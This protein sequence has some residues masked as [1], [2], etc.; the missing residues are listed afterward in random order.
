MRRTRDCVILRP[1]EHFGVFHH[2]SDAHTP[3]SDVWR[4]RR[5][6]AFS[7]CATCARMHVSLL[8]IHIFFIKGHAFFGGRCER[9]VHGTRCP[10]GR[11]ASVARIPGH[12]SVGAVRCAGSL[13][14]TRA[15]EPAGGTRKCKRG[16]RRLVHVRALARHISIITWAARQTCA[17]GWASVR[18]W[19]GVLCSPIQL[20]TECNVSSHIF[21]CVFVMLRL[22]YLRRR[23]AAL[24]HNR[25]TASEFSVSSARRDR[26]A[27]I[28]KLEPRPPNQSVWLI[29]CTRARR[30]AFYALCRAALVKWMRCWSR[31]RSWVCVL[32]LCAD[33]GVSVAPK[34]N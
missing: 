31:C 29:R 28:K 2:R 34:A 15:A 23:P 22:V 1:R 12:S 16:T 5:A 10:V 24:F 14:T 27:A 9:E 11:D 25:H 32:H 6:L 17:V 7:L 26:Y 33:H 20:Y 4:D 18:V 3:R 8:Y 21:V 19:V 30:S 13:T